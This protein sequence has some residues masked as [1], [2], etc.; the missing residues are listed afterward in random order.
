M[1]ALIGLSKASGLYPECMVLSGVVVK[2]DAVAAGGFGEVYK[3][4]LR[5]QVI[6]VK[7]L[8]VFQ[9]TDMEK[10]LRVNKCA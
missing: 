7:I 9:K 4:T 3:G 6:A 2:G 10:L 1:K 8:K 5:N